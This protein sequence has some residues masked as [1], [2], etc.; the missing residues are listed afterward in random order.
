MSEELRAIGFPGY[1]SQVVGTLDCELPVG[2]AGTAISGFCR[3][4]AFTYLSGGEINGATIGRYCSIGPQIVVN[5]GQHSWDFLTTHPIASD[6]VGGGW[7]AQYEAYQ[8]IAFT[9]LSKPTRVHKKSPVIGNDVW[10]GS[11]VTIMGGV[12]VGDGA[13]IGA[14]AVVTRDVAPFQ[15]VAGNPAR[16]IRMRFEEDVVARIRAAA[17]WDY[18]LSL[19]PVRDFSNIDGF[20]SLFEKMVA[21]GAMK[22]ASFETMRIVAGQVVPQTA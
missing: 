7:V 10:I 2:T 11:R 4:G 14:G 17:W 8:R 5:P 21:D 15:I 6:R 12:T 16:P 9:E 22:P 18:D 20:L 19:M 1:P 13:I 3:I